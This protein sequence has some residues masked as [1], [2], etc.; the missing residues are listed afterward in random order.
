MPLE[1]TRAL[2]G[3]RGR[4]RA[5]CAGGVWH[6]SRTGSGGPRRCR[7]VGGDA[8]R[9]CD[10]EYGLAGGRGPGRGRGRCGHWWGE[11]RALAG[12]GQASGSAAPASGSA[13]PSSSPAAGANTKGSAGS[14]PANP[15]SAGRPTATAPKAPGS[16]AAPAA[17]KC[18]PCSPVVLA[19]IGHY[20]G[21]IG[22]AS[23]PYLRGVQAAIASL[24]RKGG[25]NGHPVQLIVYDDGVDPARTRSNAKEAVEQKKVIGILQATSPVTYDTVIDYLNQKRI[26]TVGLT[27]ANPSDYSSPM[28]FPQGTGGRLFNAIVVH[29]IVQQVKPSGKT[30]L[31]AI[32]C[33]EA[34]ACNEQPRPVIERTAKEE[35]LQIVY[36][37][38]SSITQPDF[39]AECLQ[40]KNSGV[41]VLLVYLDQSSVGR[42]ASSCSRQGFQPIYSVGAVIPSDQF[43]SSP[44]IENLVSATGVAPFFGRGTP[45]FDE[46]HAA[47]GTGTTLG[48]GSMAGWVSGKLFERAA[49]SM[50]EP[51]TTDALLQ[52]LWS[53]KNDDLGGLTSQLVFTPNQ[54]PT[55]IMCWW[56]VTLKKGQWSSPDGYQRNC[57]PAPDWLKTP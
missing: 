50:P 31:G 21:P 55:P 38:K 37:A 53:V 23:I 13:K 7:I 16:G 52:G 4:R 11:R 5:D 32:F 14:S 40:A 57:R 3:R 20:S 46:F 45:A 25:A 15:S 34:P 1:W 39:T 47:I 28:L 49:A 29:G 44:G 12:R 30:K 6:P 48:V 9:R 33:A 19:T 26:P 17:G 43:K 10:P 35:G 22:V 8:G 54:P 41:E 42:M 51:P 24:N 2:A 56:N 27:L 18:S 36:Q